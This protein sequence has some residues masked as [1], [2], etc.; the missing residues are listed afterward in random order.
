MR[1]AGGIEHVAAGRVDEGPGER[2]P[3]PVGR[4]DPAPVIGARGALQPRLHGE[5]VAER[6]LGEARVG[7]IRQVAAQQRGDLLIGAFQHALVYGDADQRRD[8]ALGGRL[9]VGRPVHRPAGK[10]ARGEP[11]P[12]LH[13]EHGAQRREI[14]GAVEDGGEGVR[15]GGLGVGAPAPAGGAV[16]EGF[17]AAAPCAKPRRGVSSRSGAASRERRCMKGRIGRDGGRWGH[18]G[19]RRCSPSTR[20]PLNGLS[21][22]SIT[23]IGLLR[24]QRIAL[25]RPVQVY[26]Q[27]LKF[28]EH[29]ATG[30]ASRTFYASLL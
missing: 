2:R 22:R 14:A 16:A 5:Q 11:A 13:D 3:H 6:D 17:S 19:G 4:S 30:T 20:S 24:G 26:G 15:R 28:L 1:R 23:L 27:I 25:N 29:S 21:Q 10:A 7:V 18:D 8:D 9:D 12:V